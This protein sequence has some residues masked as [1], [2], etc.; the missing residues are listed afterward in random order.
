MTNILNKLIIFLLIIFL[1][2]CGFKIRDNSRFSEYYI[3][4]LETNSN[5]INFFI[6]QDLK[7]YF[8]NLNAPNKIS[9]FVETEQ[10]NK[11]SEKNIKKEVTRYE[12]IITTKVLVKFLGSQE[13]KEIKLTNNGYYDV[14]NNHSVT[15]KNKKNIQI[16]LAKKLSGEIVNFISTLKNDF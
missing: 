6:K 4:D 11:I 3:L 9:V 10:S 1:C 5:N 16:I 12:I 14:G 13:Q 7:R 2:S 15:M 8:N